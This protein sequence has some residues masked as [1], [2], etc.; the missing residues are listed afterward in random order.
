MN[1]IITGFRS[2]TVWTIIATIVLNGVP[3]VTGMLP[4]EYL[5]LVNT[6][7]G[8]LAIHFR[9]NARV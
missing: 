8:A 3:S 9:V 7:L 2:R 5:P 4:Q 1:K 6:L